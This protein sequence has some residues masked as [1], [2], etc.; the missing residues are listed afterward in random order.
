[1]A[2]SQQRSDGARRAARAGCLGP[3]LGADGQAAA[4]L[5]ERVDGVAHRLNQRLRRRRR[6]RRHLLHGL[7]DGRHGLA[8]SRR[9]RRCRRLRRERL[10][11]HRGGRRRGLTR[12]RRA[13]RSRAV[14]VH[15]GSALSGR[16]NPRSQSS[17]KRRAPRGSGRGDDVSGAR[18]SAATSH[19]KRSAAAPEQPAKAAEDA[20]AA[21]GERDHGGAGHH[22]E[23]ACNSCR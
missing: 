4:G 5:H 19:L 23:S 14:A 12:W 10:R 9:R 20:S 15:Q 1:M 3:P 21:C 22:P 7:G 2:G 8:P 13:R 17:T 11:R 6:Q 18:I 16:W